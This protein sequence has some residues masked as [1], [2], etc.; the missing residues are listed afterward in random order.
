MILANARCIEEIPWW[1]QA[2]L[3]I[4]IAGGLGALL[5]AW[6]VDARRRSKR[7]RTIRDARR[8]NRERQRHYRNMKL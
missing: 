6:A 5:F 7:N 3:S 4:V 2:V 1:L 8:R